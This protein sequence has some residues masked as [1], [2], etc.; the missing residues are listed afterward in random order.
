MFKDITS[1]LKEPSSLHLAIEQLAK[2]YLKEDTTTAVAEIKARGFIFGSL[3]A[4]L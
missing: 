3:V 4:S 2:P 1:L